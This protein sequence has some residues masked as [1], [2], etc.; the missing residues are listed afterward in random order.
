MRALL[1]G[2]ALGTT[3]LNELRAWQYPDSLDLHIDS[4]VSASQ[5]PASPALDTLRRLVH[6]AN[7]KAMGFDSLAD[8]GS[9]VLGQPLVIFR[10]PLTELR[11]FNPG[12]DPWKILRPPASVFYPVLVGGEARSAVVI[13]EYTKRWR[14]II[15]GGANAARTA[16]AAI[17]S[18]DS[19]LGPRPRRYFRVDVLAPG[20]RFI[21]FRS[22]LRL[23]LVPLINDRK[24]RWKAGVPITADSV[25]AQLAP[26]ARAYNE[27]PR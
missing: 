25:F 27:L 20:T 19:I 8:T 4:A 10:V 2:C 7:V 24:N 21:G 22:A 13:G 3:A 18:A 17:H 15:F 26:E 1:L 6:P 9:A 11:S 14:G 5:P 16:A 23:V 12:D